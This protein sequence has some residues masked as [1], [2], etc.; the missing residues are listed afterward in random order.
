MP[1]FSEFL[2]VV[3]VIGPDKAAKDLYEVAEELGFALAT[4]KILV[5]CGGRGGVMEAVCRGVYRAGGI[6]VGILPN[7]IEEA[8]SYVTVPIATHLGEARNAIVVAAGE[9]VI[10]IGGGIGTL[11]EIALALKHQKL[12]IG[13]KTWE[14]KD[15]YGYTLPILY[16]ENINKY[17]EIIVENCKKRKKTYL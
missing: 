6:S 4:H 15:N 17:I 7:G 8:N 9:I 5:V 11:S 16:V 14:A 10:A 1:S 12:V 2:G 3:S 13:F